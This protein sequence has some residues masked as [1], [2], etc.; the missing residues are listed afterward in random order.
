MSELNGWRIVP[1]A[2]T[3][4]MLDA[5]CAAD[6][7]WAQGELPKEIGPSLAVWAAA[8]QVVP[9]PFVEMSAE[10]QFELAEKLAANVGYRLVKDET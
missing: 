7:A 6:E 4:E 9:D 3:G 1:V 8:V 5:I 2:P 10:A